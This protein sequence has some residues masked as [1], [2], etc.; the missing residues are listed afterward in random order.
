MLFSLWKIDLQIMDDSAMLISVA[1]TW[2]I[3][4]MLVR[5]MFTVLDAQHGPERS[6]TCVAVQNSQKLC[7]V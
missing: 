3:C 4:A 1:E 7:C 5:L 2:F 6:I